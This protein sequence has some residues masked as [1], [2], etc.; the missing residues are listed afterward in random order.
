[1]FGKR[2]K[3]INRSFLSLSIGSQTVKSTGKNNISVINL[4]QFF[5]CN[6]HKCRQ[7]DSKNWGNG[8]AKYCK[9]LLP[10]KSKANASSYTRLMAVAGRQ[11]QPLH[12]SSLCS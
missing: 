7:H 8:Q 4:D 3:R 10:M 2:L 11:W 9:S 5:C 6:S 1:M 12:M